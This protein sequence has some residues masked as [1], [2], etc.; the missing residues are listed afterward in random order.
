MSVKTEKIILNEKRN[1]TLTTMMP[2]MEDEFGKIKSRPAVLIL[3][4]GG[5]NICT[6]SEA[7]IVAYPYLQAGYHAFVLRYSVSEHKTWPNPLIDYEQAMD[8]IRSKAEEWHVIPDKIAVIGFS[9]GGHLAACAATVARNRPA[10]AILGYAA[11]GVTLT[12][13]SHPEVAA[14]VPVEHVDDDTCP[15]FL[16]AARDDSLVPV[17]N[18]VDFELAL[19]E[20]G[21]MYESHIY[22]YGGH[23]FST[24]DE[25][26]SDGR[27]CS[28]VPRWVG[29]SIEW[30]EDLFGKLTPAGMT[31][32]ACSGKINGNSEA[33]LSVNCTIGHLMRQN[34][35][36][37][38]LLADVIA[39][40]E[41]LYPSVN[42]E[43]SA[44]PDQAREM[45]L[46]D[47][48]KSFG[49]GE[50]AIARMDEALNQI[51]NQK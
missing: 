9:A 35:S 22:A 51:S 15:C 50:D 2:A 17:R 46:W 3:P 36:V 26:L 48:M 44:I 43:D 29:D 25:S 40:S 31:A 4:G 23:G 12:N 28:R 34:N 18:T 39:F 38:N 13:L 16:F 11:T 14:I 21:I 30:L 10:A 8:M 27:Q 47:V 49:M 5:Y 20:K 41:Q 6:D 33:V 1:V 45:R 24:C 37:T 7:E 42:Q 32:P 19:I